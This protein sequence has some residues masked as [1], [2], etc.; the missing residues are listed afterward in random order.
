MAHLP[1]IRS[2]TNAVLQLNKAVCCGTGMCLFV[3]VCVYKYPRFPVSI[4]IFFF[5]W[6]VFT[7]VAPLSWRLAKVWGFTVY[8][9]YTLALATNQFLELPAMIYIHYNGCLQ[10]QSV[11][12]TTEWIW[13][14][15]NLFLE[16]IWE[17]LNTASQ[18]LCL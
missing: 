7:L 9:L 13:A 18:W 17:L 4:V 11:N 15:N 16:G 2:C 6:N 1:K 12:Q 5:V 10:I 14:K 3:L 8:F